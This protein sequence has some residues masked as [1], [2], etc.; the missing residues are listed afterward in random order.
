MPLPCKIFEYRT[1]LWRD[2]KCR[3]VH[4]DI[5]C[6]AFT[7]EH[8][9]FIFSLASSS[10]LGSP[11]LIKTY[12][13]GHPQMLSHSTFSNF[14]SFLFIVTGIYYALPSNSTNTS[15]LSILPP[16]NLYDICEH[17]HNFLL[18]LGCF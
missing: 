17:F 11:S 4:I 6:K 15:L 12:R 7:I 10:L 2:P 9:I 8:M 3:T 16:N 5:P 14:F 18:K 1:P 13:Y